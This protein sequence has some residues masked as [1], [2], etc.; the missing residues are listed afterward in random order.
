MPLFRVKDC[1]QDKKD[2]RGEKRSANG[3][4]TDKEADHCR[5][6][7]FLKRIDLKGDENGA[8]PPKT[9][10]STVHCQNISK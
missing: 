5:K 6:D 8:A 7:L 10:A 2:S 1:F 4:K 9:D 3:A